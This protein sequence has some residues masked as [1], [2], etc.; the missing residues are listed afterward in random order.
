MI[1][2]NQFIFEHLCTVINLQLPCHI[3]YIYQHAVVYSTLESHALHSLP[4]N[5][6]TRHW[7]PDWKKPLL[8][9]LLTAYSLLCVS[10]W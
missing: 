10:Y 3:F 1:N 7:M 9:Y 8:T 2:R 6:V 4:V 5:P